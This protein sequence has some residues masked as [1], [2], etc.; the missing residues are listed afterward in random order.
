MA[1][2]YLFMAG[3]RLG[4]CARRGYQ[5]SEQRPYHKA[6]TTIFSARSNTT[7]LLGHWSVIRVC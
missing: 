4:Y 5:T 1:Q 2:N 7:N 3:I 6:V